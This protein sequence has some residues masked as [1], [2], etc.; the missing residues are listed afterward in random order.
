[1]HIA[2]TFAPSDA[3]LC[4]VRPD[5]PVSPLLLSDRLISLAKD[6]DRAGLT[7]TATKILML[8]YSVL[9]EPPAA[10]ADFGGELLASVAEASGILRGEVP[11]A[12]FWPGMPDSI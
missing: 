10:V 12:R 6:A 3:G 7:G 1:M 2:S 8:A 9:D 11:P 4:L 5:A